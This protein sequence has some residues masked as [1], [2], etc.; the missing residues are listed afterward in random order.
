MKILYLS[1][2]EILEYD[3]VSLFHKLGYDIFSPGAY[4]EPQ[5][6]GDQDLR[7]SISTLKYSDEIREQFYKLSIKHPGEDTKDYLDKAFV[8][9]FD[10]VIVMHMPR[11]IIRNWGVMKHKRVIWRTIGQSVAS[12]EQSLLPYRKEG[13]Q[14]VR[15]S[16]RE[17]QIPGFIGQD[18]LIRFCKD[19]ADYSSWN[20]DKEQVITFSQ[21]MQQRGTHCNYALF[22]EVTKLFSRKLF[23]P[24][25]NQPGF[26]IGK[27]P[28][29]QLKQ[30]MRDSRVY[31]YTGTH[32]ASYTLNFIEAWMTGIP[33]VAIGPEHGNAAYLRNHDLYEIPD[34][35]QNGVNG[36]ISDDPGFLHKKIKQLLADKDLATRIGNAGR[37]EAVRHFNSDM[38]GNAWKAFLR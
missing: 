34:L 17:C 35:I 37:K 12:T 7:P 13:L 29:E 11:W 24:G 1:C 10:V 21:S 9:N 38:I 30:E 32:P 33:I 26:G 25:N 20:G 6:R 16:P 14:V 23:G 36:F 5:N 3:E 2:H 18:A 27:V 22:N 8:D 4:V 19:P 28:Y 31:F 15:Y